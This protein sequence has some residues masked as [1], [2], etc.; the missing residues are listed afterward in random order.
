[1][2]ISIHRNPTGPV[3][4]LLS[5]LRTYASRGRGDSSEGS[6]LIRFTLDAG[7]PGLKFGLSEPVHPAVIVVKSSPALLDLVLEGC[8]R[9]MRCG[10]LEAG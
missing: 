5:V 9:I 10:H 8:D 6:P 2:R 4:L 7:Y 1:M 3:T